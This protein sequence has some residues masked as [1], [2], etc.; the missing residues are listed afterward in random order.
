MKSVT[1]PT[2]AEIDLKAIAHNLRGVRRRVGKVVH[3][4][5]VVKANAYGHGLVEVGKF[6]TEGYADYLGVAIPEEG[7][8][9][10]TAG[11]K[12]PIHVFTLPT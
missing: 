10:R 4:M 3:I 11:I 7:A 6:V 5:A 9:L 8:R 1:R 2:V 12:K